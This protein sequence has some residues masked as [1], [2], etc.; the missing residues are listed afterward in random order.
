MFRKRSI[1]SHIIGH[2]YQATIDV[3]LRDAL[4]TRKTSGIRCARSYRTLRDGSFGGRFPGTSCQA[5]ISLSLRDEKY[6]LRAEALIKLALMGLKP[7]AQFHCPLRGKNPALWPNREISLKAMPF[8][9][10]Q[11]LLVANTPTLQHSRHSNTPTLQH[12]NTP[13]LQHSNTPTLHHSN[14]PTLQHSNTPTLQH[15]ITPTLQHSNTPS[16]HHSITPTLQHS[17]TPHSITPSLLT[18]PQLV[19]GAV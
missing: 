2:F 14:T 11:F 9:K 3:V 16:L 12:S 1:T 18:A 10:P 7:R 13:T 5:T 19:F 6:I 8:L 4:S 17:N 15:S